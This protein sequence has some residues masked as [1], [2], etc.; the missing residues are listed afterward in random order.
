MQLNVTKKLNIHVH[1]QCTHIHMQ[2]TEIRLYFII[3]HIQHIHH[4]NKLKQSLV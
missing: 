4:E 1:I 2:Q 3:E